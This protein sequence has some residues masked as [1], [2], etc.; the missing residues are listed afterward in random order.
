MGIT[1]LSPSRYVQGPGELLQLG[2]YAKMLAERPAVFLVA[3]KEDR[4]RVEEQLA[5][6][7]DGL[8]LTVVNGEFNGR[9]T[10]EEVTR[11]A[12]GCAVGQCGVVVGL[13]GG[14]AL[15][16]AKAVAYERRLPMIIVPTVASTDAPCSATAVLYKESGELSR[17][18]QL[19]SPPELVLVDTAVIA[20]APVRFL[21]AGMGDALSTWFEARA[22]QRSRAA[23]NSS[24]APAISQAAMAIAERCYQVLRADSAAARSACAEGAVSDALER[25]VEANLLLSGLAFESC[26]LAAAHA[27]HNGLTLLPETRSRLHGEIVAFCTIV[28]LVLEQAEPAEVAEVRSYCQAMGLPVRL[29]DLGLDAAA[30]TAKLLL[31]AEAACRAAGSPMGNMPFPVTP[32]GVYAALLAAD[33]LP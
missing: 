11:L 26:G 33:R 32:D 16:A 1:F 21:V 9:C 2:K 7:W 8:L 4:E 19:D 23:H 29:A 5:A 6:A 3:A 12:R 24:G 20:K 30:D 14:R 27:I 10:E 13:G 17:Y 18:L 28:Q 22:N 15:D 25:I 31:A